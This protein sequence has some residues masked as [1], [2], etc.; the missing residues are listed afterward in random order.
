VSKIFKHPSLLYATDIA[1]I[2]SPLNKIDISYFCHV[3]ISDQ[4]KFA[5]LSCNPKFTEHYLKN[6]YYMGDIHMVDANRLGNF[7]IWNNVELGKEKEKMCLEAADFGIKNV[8]TI[9]DRSKNGIDYFHF[10]ND[11]PTREFNQGYLAK[12]ELLQAFIHYF[13]N[14]IQQSKPLKKAYDFKFDLGPQKLML[15]NDSTVCDHNDF[16][17]CLSTNKSGT[18]LNIDDVLL[19]KRQSDVVH[20]AMRGKTQKEISEILNLSQRTVRHYFDA[21]KLKLNVY[22]RSELISKIFDLGSGVLRGL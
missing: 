10:A 21:V 22:S 13:K 3:Q 17:E 18:R 5:A 9:I 6:K 12:L 4:K 14:S 8:F 2:C 15:G 7:F 11:L 19:S 1:E 16:L 20:L